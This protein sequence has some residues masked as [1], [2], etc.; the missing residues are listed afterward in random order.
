[1]HA[2]RRQA[3]LVQ[4]GRDR[5]YQERGGEVSGVGGRLPVALSVG[6]QMCVV[7]RKKGGTVRIGQDFRG[8]NALLKTGNGGDLVGIAGIFD[9]A[10]YF[11][12]TD[13]A[14]GFTQLDIAEDDTHKTAFRD[15]YGELWEFNRCDFGLKTLPSCFAAHAGEVLGLLKR[16]GVRS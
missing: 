5:K 15:A 9:G 10:G 12:S 8:L 7:V 4:A 16:R 14:L 13:L 1:M 2:T 3:A 6:G 11:P